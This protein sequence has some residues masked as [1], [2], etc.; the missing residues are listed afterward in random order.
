MEKKGTQNI[1][2]GPKGDPNPQKGPHGDP[3][4]L[5]GT[6][7]GTV[8]LG[9]WGCLWPNMSFLGRKRPFLGTSRAPRW[10]FRGV[11]RVQTHP[12]GCVQQCSTMFNQCSTHLG[13]LGLPMAN[14]R[15]F[16]ANFGQKWP[17]SGQKWPKMM[18]I[19]VLLVEHPITQP[20]G[21]D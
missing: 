1:K 4:P 14:K 8:H 16:G 10:H 6:H 18:K 19:E 5:K 2:R 20:T 12:P 21:Q 11:K 15:N 7:L 3:G 17:K 13:W 9:C